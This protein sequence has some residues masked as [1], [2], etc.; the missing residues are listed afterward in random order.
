[1]DTGCWEHHFFRR[2]ESVEGHVCLT[3]PVR[4]IWFA[5]NQF[6]FQHMARNGYKQMWNALANLKIYLKAG[7]GLCFVNE[8]HR[9]S[10]YPSKVSIR[11]RLQC[12]LTLT[13]TLFCPLFEKLCASVSCWHFVLPKR[14]VFLERLTCFSALDYNQ[15]RSMSKALRTT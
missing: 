1:M 4:K 2:N 11:L 13:F 3:H 8:E 14:G 6:C 7:S 10:Y 15:L 5:Y 9:I 12:Q